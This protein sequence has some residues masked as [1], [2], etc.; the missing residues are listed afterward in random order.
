MLRVEAQRT[1]AEIWA[2][3]VGRTTARGTKGRRA[4]K[5]VAWRVQAVG[6]GEEGRRKGMEEVVRQVERGVMSLGDVAPW[7]RVARVVRRRGRDMVR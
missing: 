3:V 1:A 7:A 2:V 5:V 6:L 4:L